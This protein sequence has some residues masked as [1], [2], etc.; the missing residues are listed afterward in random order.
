MPV[1]SIPQIDPIARLASTPWGALQGLAVP[2][3]A[4]LAEILSGR[5][6]E[7]VLHRL[8][9]D[10][11]G[12][13]AP[14]RTAL[15]EAVFGVG[16]WRRRLAWH[17]GL[18]DW[19]A[20]EPRWLLF[21]LLRDLA[22]LPEGEAARLSTVEPFAAPA[23]RAAP[24]DLATAWSFPDWLAQL[25]QRELGDEA[26]AFARALDVP[27]PVYVRVNAL[28][29][30][31]ESLLA[32]LASEGVQARLAP[33]ARCALLLD[34][35]PNILGLASH[36]EGLF[37]VQDEGSQL[38]GELVEAQPG[39]SVL[40]FCAGA[41]GKALLLAG[42]LRNRGTLYVHDPDAERLDRLLL[43]ASRAGVLGLQLLRGAVPPELLVDRVLVD[44]PCSSLGSLRRGPDVRWRID[45]AALDAW[46]PLQRELLASAARHVRPG[47]RL[48]Y[49][50][51]TVRREENQEVSLDFE[52]RHPDF[53]RLRP[54][55]GWLAGDFVRDGFFQCFPHRH[56]TDA[57]F[58]AVYERRA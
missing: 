51:C 12:L 50:T 31:R 13:S 56:G 55:E 28:R 37:Q 11:R 53:I 9:R 26:D 30:D 47:G 49:A 18:E 52:A 22:G 21:A 42:C 8:L 16:L 34:G 46:P 15:A 58:A 3:S 1:L 14:Q 2:L 40:D 38:L 25:F 17:L 43:R 32:R 5:P 44:A 36:Q 41:G 4:A 20:A 27:G 23:R 39:D 24:A 54:G 33:H 6:A 35:R 7:K 48:V 19:G 57:F 10:R 45:P 29:T